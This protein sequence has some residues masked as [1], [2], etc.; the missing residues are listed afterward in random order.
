RLVEE[1]GRI[2]DMAERATVV[3]DGRA[4]AGEID[5][6]ARAGVSIAFAPGGPNA[7][8]DAIVEMVGALDRPGDTTVVT[9]DRGLVERLRPFGV[10]IESAKTFRSRLDA[11]PR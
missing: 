5:G 9:S 8:D 3:F 1:M 7:A 2:A 4:T 11:P 6:A 10:K